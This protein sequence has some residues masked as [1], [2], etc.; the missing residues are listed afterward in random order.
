MITEQNVGTILSATGTPT[1]K[2]SKFFVP[3]LT[4]LT[5]N[6]YTI[7]DPFSFAE[8]FLNYDSN[9]I[10]VNFDVELLFTNIP[11]QEAIDLSV[12]L[13]FNDKSNVYSFTITDFHQL[14]T[15]TM[16]ESLVLFDGEYYKQIDGV[17]MGSP[18]GPTFANILLSYR[19][20]IWL[21]NCP[22]EF[23]PVIDKRYVDD[24]SLLFRSKDHIEKFRCYLNCQHPNIKFTSE[25]E[26]NNS[27]SFL[28]IKITRVN[29][30][31][32]TSIYRK[33]TFSGVFTN[34][35]SFIPVSYKSNLI[36]TLLFRVFKLC[37][38]FELFHPEILN[39]KDIFKR[40]GYPYNF[41]DVCIKIFLNN[42]SID[43]MV[44]ALAP[45][46]ELICALPFI[47]KKSLQLRS[48]LVKSVHNN[49]SFCHLKVVFLSPCKL[50]TLF[51][52]KDTLDK[53]IRSDLVY[54]C[55]CSSCNATYY[56]KTYRHFFTRSA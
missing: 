56:G 26:E 51:R 20:Q 50:C 47:G 16:S 52:F 12:K 34:F 55:W 37:S 29:N 19:E 5:L 42:I 30:S 54:R 14:L 39:L 31:F 22:C 2:L 6:E 17:A 25:I 23:K 45:K 7:K 3:L 11:I 36:F 24:T 32:S 28:D 41:I 40:N 13:L 33:V 44:Y 1:H 4:P 18:L 9:L 8:E 43:K 48:K 21:I 38:N 15:V 46:K 10:M 35:E 53:K 27:R 49:S